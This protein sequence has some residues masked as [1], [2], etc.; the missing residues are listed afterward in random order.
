[1]RYISRHIDVSYQ[2]LANYDEEGETSSTPRLRGTFNLTNTGTMTLRRGNWE[3]YMP[4]FREMQFHVNGTM[5]GDSGLKAG[6]LFKGL[7]DAVYS[8]S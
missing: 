5:L 6:I 2:V 3:L 1:V 8:M 4:S 7:F